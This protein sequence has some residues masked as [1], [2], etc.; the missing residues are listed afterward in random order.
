[1]VQLLQLAEEKQA[2]ARA[3]CAVGTQ[4]CG[5]VTVL[6]TVPVDVQLELREHCFEPVLQSSCNQHSL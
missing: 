2:S 3:A 4:A 6:F 5:V 1:V